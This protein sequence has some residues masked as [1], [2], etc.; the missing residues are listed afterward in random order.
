MWETGS[1]LA[2]LQKRAGRKIPSPV[3]SVHE[4]ED[5]SLLKVHGRNDRAP[6][7][8]IEMDINGQVV[9][10]ELDTRATYSLV[11]K[12]T[13]HDHWPK[14]ALTPSKIRLCSYSGKN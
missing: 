8:M 9:K 12:K 5:Y 14:A 13:Y 1:H 7:I 6:P 10:L 2:C 3:R 11:S 4:D